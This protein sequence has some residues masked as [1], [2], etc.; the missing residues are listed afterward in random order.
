MRAA[1]AR[2]HIIGDH[3]DCSRF[4]TPCD[5]TDTRHDPRD[6]RVSGIA[7]P[8]VRLGSGLTAR[9]PRE[10]GNLPIGS[11]IR[12]FPLSAP[13]TRFTLGWGSSV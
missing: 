3:A 8:P 9:P 6:R 4:R 1:R 11:V 7:D 12:C 5:R 2:I 10:T 13:A